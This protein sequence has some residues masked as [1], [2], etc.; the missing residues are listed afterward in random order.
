MTG[1]G[2]CIDSRCR[3]GS[4]SGPPPCLGSAK[5]KEYIMYPQFLEELAIIIGRLGRLPAGLGI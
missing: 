2:A 1:F 3:K 5:R 4:I